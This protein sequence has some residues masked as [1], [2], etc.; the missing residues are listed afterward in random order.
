MTDAKDSKQVPASAP[1]GLGRFLRFS[2]IYGLGDL[3]AKGARII[4]IPFYLSVMT[5]AEVGELAVLQAASYGAWTLLGFGF[6]FGVQKYY[7][8]Y[9]Q[10]ADAMASSLWVARLIGGLP[11]LGLL[12]LLGVGLHQWSSNLMSLPLL[13]LSITGG[14]LRGGINITEFWLNIR[15]E[16]VKYRMFT[17]GQFLLTSLLVIYLVAVAKMGVAGVVWGE[18]ISYGC[19]VFISA[20]MM[21]GKAMPDFK[22]VRWKEIFGYC[23]PALPHAFFMWGLM[24]VDR[25]ILNEYVELPEIGIYSVAFLLGSFLSIVVRSM[26]AAWLPAFFKNA[27]DKDSHQQFGKIASVYLVLTFFTAVSGIYFSAEIVGLFSLTSSVSYAE[28]ARMMQF[29]LVGFVA[30]AL[31]LAVNQPLFYERRTGLLSLISGAGLLVNIASNLVLVPRLGAWGAVYSYIL[32]YSMM[33]IIT[34]WLTN[35]IYKIQWQSAEML[36]ASGIFVLFCAGATLLPSETILWL[37]PVKAVAVMAFAILMLFRITPSRRSI[38]KLESKFAWSKFSPD[39]TGTE[40]V[41]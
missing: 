34:L 8:D 40:T 30:M 18:L 31:F 15:E 13:L 21:F 25:L 32:A 1:Q 33:A 17:F 2:L 12:M 6:A 26:R 29:L 35:R 37:L 14:F 27:A 4:L 20:A 9:G 24:G 36:S 11:F 5:Q 39:K 23:L 38:L 16:P 7:Y 28:S 3:M 22:I 19:F 10:H 41:A